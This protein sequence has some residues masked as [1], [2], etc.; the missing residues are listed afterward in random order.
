[1]FI[2]LVWFIVVPLNM[3]ETGVENLYIVLYKAI[4]Y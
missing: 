4:E 1:M 3:V 2:I